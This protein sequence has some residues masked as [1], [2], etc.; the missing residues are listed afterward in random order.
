[1]WPWAP[2]PE[3]CGRHVLAFER[4]VHVISAIHHEWMVLF[5]VLAEIE[6]LDVCVL[7]FVGEREL[8]GLCFAVRSQFSELPVREISCVNFYVLS[9][10]N[11]I[12]FS[13]AKNS[14]SDSYLN[15]T[16]HCPAINLIV[17]VLSM[18]V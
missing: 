7:S 6:H 3:V 8:T 4:H 10:L 18:L 1:M 9:D 2:V 15:I 5:P 13:A 12:H 17:Y 16:V 14:A 11:L